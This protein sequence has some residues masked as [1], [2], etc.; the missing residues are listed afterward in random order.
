M[1]AALLMLHY[2]G[3]PDSASGVRADK[4]ARAVASLGTEVVI[5]HS[6]N[7]DSVLETVDGV[8]ERTFRRTDPSGWR[9]RKRT[10]DATSSRDGA[11]PGRSYVA[12]P[13]R[14]FVRSLLQPDEMV[15]SAGSFG[16][17]AYAE[18]RRLQELGRSVLVLA[19]GPPWS[20]MLVGRRIARRCMV[21]LVLDF[22]DLWASNPVVRRPFL[23]RMLA[24]ELERRCVAAARGTVFVN[25][26]VG[27]DLM[28]WHPE[29]QSRPH[30]VA[31]IGFRGDVPVSLAVRP[32]SELRIGHFGSL[33]GDR[34]FRALL[35]AGDR[36]RVSGRR[37]VLHWFGVMHDESPDR[38]RMIGAIDSG[39]L[40]MH[41]AV[42]RDE[43]LQLMRECDLLLT[44]PSPSYPQELTTKLYDYLEAGRPILALAQP[45]SLLDR[46][47]R[48]SDVGRAFAPGDS[49]GVQAFIETCLATGMTFRPIRAALAPHG[50]LAGASGVAGL[51][52]QLLGR[53]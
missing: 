42:P 38:A 12:R 23:W 8:R 40:V 47:V 39:L 28:D 13:L 31:P 2:H 27:N 48:E 21:P 52:N 17:A 3:P 45:G 46:L 4:L 19:S 26:E 51:L 24:R 43:A 32:A 41:G 30:T 16:R 20:T 7:D 1:K 44:V 25:R 35:E 11:L 5:V 14:R 53:E 50:L 49:D 33:Y 18:C 29:L 22:Q 15:L 6:G 37:V 34:S 9:E 36:L 10:R